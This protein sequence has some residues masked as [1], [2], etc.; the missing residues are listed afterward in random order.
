MK[1]AVTGSEGQL[2]SDVMIALRAH[3]HHAVGLTR[4]LLDITDEEKTRSILTELEPDALIHCAAYTAVDDAEDHEALCREVNASGTR[5]V[6]KA[7]KAMDIPLVY[8]STDYVFD[9]TGHRPYEV[10]DKRNPQNVYGKTK[11]EGEAFVESLLDKYYIVRISWVFGIH[12]KNFVK[13][14]L[15]HGKSRKVL[16]VVNDQI[17]SPT[18]TR[19]VAEFL[20]SLMVSKDY[21]IY[22][23]TNSGYCSWFDFAQKIFELSGMK[24][25]RV[26]PVSSSA[27]VTKAKRPMNS[28]LS[29]ECL[30]RQGFT[31]LPSWEDALGRFIKELSS[32]EES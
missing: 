17:G 26:E 25:V 5:N 6:A 20:M 30:G 29:K 8:I 4:E 23:A 10:T 2:G 15:K 19:D 18:Y 1:V 22:H 7:C 24:D 32:T 9:G 21:G 13:T 27:Y 14:M 3:G 12:G 31:A 28:R 11:A 16:Q